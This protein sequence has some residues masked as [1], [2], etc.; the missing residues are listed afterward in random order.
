MRST[1][2]LDACKL[3]TEA[4]LRIRTRASKYRKSSFTNGIALSIINKFKVSEDR[5]IQL[6]SLEQNC[7]LYPSY[8]RVLEAKHLCYNSKKI[9]ESSSKV[10]L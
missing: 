3:M 4:A 7:R 1:G 2:Q 8:K 10:G 9:S 6:T 5:S